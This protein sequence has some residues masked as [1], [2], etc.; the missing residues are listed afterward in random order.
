[1]N[2]KDYPGQIEATLLELATT[3]REIEASRD[4][5]QTF[6]DEFLERVLKAQKEGKPLYTNDHQRS[7]AIRDLQRQSENW[8]DENENL[9]TSERERRRLMAKLERLRG[10]FS[11]AKL[12]RRAEIAAMEI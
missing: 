3:E 4:I 11:I 5:L 6:E 9:V 1:M 10:E 2:L 8:Q 7:A 12:E